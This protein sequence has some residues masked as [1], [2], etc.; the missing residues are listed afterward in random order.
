MAK[1]GPKIRYYDEYHKVLRER[2][3]EYRARLKL[4]A[5]QSQDIG[6]LSDFERKK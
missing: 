1:R 5:E 4:Q 3:R 6:V 2:V